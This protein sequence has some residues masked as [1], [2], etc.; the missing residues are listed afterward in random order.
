MKCK[1]IDKIEGNIRG[2][3]KTAFEKL[4]SEKT[5]MF[6]DLVATDKPDG[7]ISNLPSLEEIKNQIPNP[8]GWATGMEDCV[9]NGGIMIEALIALY[10]KTK[11]KD[12]LPVLHEVFEG[13]LTC[14]T[15][16][17]QEGFLA[18]GVSPIDGKSHYINSSR[19]Q[20]THWVWMS[21]LFYKSG[22]AT[23]EEKK[24]ITNVLV[25]MARKAEREIYGENYEYLREDGK[26]GLVCKMWGSLDSHE[27]LRLPMIYLAAYYTSKDEHWKGKYLEYREEAFV[28]SESIYGDGAMNIFVY[29]YALLQMQYSLKLVYE[30]EEDIEYKNRAAKMMNFLAD[31]SERYTKLGVAE[32]ENPQVDPYVDWRQEKAIYWGC[33]NGYAYYVPMPPAD[34][35]RE[36]NMRNS[37]EA[38]LIRLL[39]VENKVGDD[40]KKM[41]EYIIDNVKFEYATNYWPIIF[42]DAWAI[43]IDY[44]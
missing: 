37:A 16:S 30:A 4:Y 31:Y 44:K 39:S 20:Y 26:V 40:Q 19:D 2:A 36:L 7:N 29:A 41:F 32:V 15:V 3:W 28:K 17:D 33:I 10:E 5:K 12:I 11:D 24:A 1:F 13:F 9:L 23:K 42:C 8:S 35:S 18:R 43:L 6:Y 34:D 22:L 25:G 14:A 21:F 38:I 27:Y